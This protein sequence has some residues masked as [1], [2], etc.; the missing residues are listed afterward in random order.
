MIAVYIQYIV[1]VLGDQCTLLC[2]G[3]GTVS[4]VLQR[5]VA[6]LVR[7][8]YLEKSGS[9]KCSVKGI[10]GLSEGALSPVGVILSDLYAHVED[11]HFLGYVPFRGVLYLYTEHILKG[12]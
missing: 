11:P 2:E 5:G 7:V 12:L 4:C 6:L 10:R 1:S 9:G 8:L 3:K